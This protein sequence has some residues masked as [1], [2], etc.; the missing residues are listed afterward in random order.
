MIDKVILAKV[1]KCLALS[2][3]ANEHEAAAALA[4]ARQ[5]MEEHG[6]TDAML[7]MAD[8]GE[9][10]AKAS[11][12]RRPPHWESILAKTVCHALSVRQFVTGAGDRNFIGRDPRPEIACYAFAVLFRQ[13]KRARAD[14]IAS[15]LKRCKPG[16]KRSRADT[17]CEGWAA[18]VFLKVKDLMPEPQP[19]PVVDHYL[20]ETHPSLVAIDSR[21]ANQARAANDFWRGHD[22]GRSVDLNI[23]V[24]SS[25]TAPL[26]I[27]GLNV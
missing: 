26:Q 10:T 15:Q 13:L 16:R 20:V 3:S 18:A 19:D 14:Y 8:I 21:R 11:G 23:A 6:I 25:T 4:K 27:G 9:K 12:N 22:K 24:G 1:R 7:A 2:R 17:F 5:L